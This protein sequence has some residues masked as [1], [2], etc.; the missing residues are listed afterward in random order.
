MKV[1]LIGIDLAKNVFQVCGINQAGKSVF[2]RALKR[3]QL[4][5]FLFK[6]PDSIIAMEAC[7][8]SNYWGRELLTKGFE[9]RLIPPQH[10]KPFVK[11]NKND[12]NDA[13]AICEA[14][15]RP[16]LT[17]VQ[18]RTL[19]QTDMILAHRI[20]E[21][22]VENRTSLINQIR[23]LLNEYGVVIAQG[24]ERLKLAIPELLENADSGLT[25]IARQHF[26]ALLEE[27]KQVDRTIKNL[28]KN[29]KSQAKLNHQTNR[30]MGIK[31]VAEITATA[32]VAF[33]GNGAQYHNGRHFAAN[34]G[35]VPREYSSG[36]KQKLGKITK[37]GNNYLRR[38]LV[39]GAWSIIRYVGNSTDRMSVWAKKLIERRGKHKAAVAV[40][41]KLARII[42][43]MLYNQTEYRAN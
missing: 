38:L 37:R 7:S 8:G 42:W 34:L 33:A 19:E 1:T 21:R 41:N 29:I 22:N 14:A 17:F 23:G 36:G 16:N 26:Q 18:P 15:L 5:A 3:S 27:W 31:G 40:A 12:R 6:Y 30:L 20:R 35:L 4:M 2:N 32:A 9:V 43:S 39:Q 11:G 24:K 28:E 13:F 10:V 25:E